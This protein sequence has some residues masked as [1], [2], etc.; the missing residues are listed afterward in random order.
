MTHY[1]NAWLKAQQYLWNDTRFHSFPNVPAIIP[2]LSP[3]N[4]PGF[5]FENASK[6]NFRTR[7]SPDFV[8]RY[9]SA[10]LVVVYFNQIEMG[11]QIDG[12]RSDVYGNL[13][14]DH[15]YGL[16]LYFAIFHLASSVFQE[17]K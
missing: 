6:N 13:I 16:Q 11:P 15:S 1:A 7:H 8:Y 3:E 2:H 9:L 4:E 12:I 17:S 5:R 10:G 14:N